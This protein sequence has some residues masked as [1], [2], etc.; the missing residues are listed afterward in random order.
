[1]GGASMNDDQITKHIKTRTKTQSRVDGAVADAMA[2]AVAP[3][4]EVSEYD[5]DDEGPSHLVWSLGIT[6]DV[7]KGMRGDGVDAIVAALA[8]TP[9]SID[10]IMALTLINHALD[11]VFGQE[12]A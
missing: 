6:D 9:G 1:M 11:R 7:R 5:P 10:R 3:W 4:A 2:V 8:G 12:P